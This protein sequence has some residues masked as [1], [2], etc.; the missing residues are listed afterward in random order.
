MGLALLAEACAAVGDSAHAETLAAMLAPFAGRHLVSPVAAYVGPVNRYL[1]LLASARG[2]HE[3]S[4][5]L[6]ATARE[7]AGLLGAR[8]MLAT[9]ALDEARVHA[10]RSAHTAGA[11]RAHEAAALASE[12]G[13]EA[14]SARAVQLA[15]ELSA[16]GPQTTSAERMPTAADAA[17]WGGALR[18]EGDVWNLRWDGRTMLLRDSKGLRYLARLL[19]DPGVEVHSLDL[20]RAPASAPSSAHARTQAILGDELQARPSGEPGMAALDD[21]A[22]REYRRRLTELREELA[23]AEDWGDPERAVAAREEM[24]AIAHELA[25]AVGLSG[26]D[27]QTGSSAERA[28]VNATR[29]I[30]G[31]ISRIGDAD[32]VLGHHLATTVKTGTFCSYRPRPGSPGWDIGW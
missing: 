13:L 23:E 29:A 4:L 32:D 25:A 3:R 5:E 14:L 20:V 10:A 22:K 9:I 6:L 27:R 19:A 15:D 21:R 26:R 31:A 11:R 17:R 18:R 2:D 16:A 7:E 8:P 28:R 12:L 1:G 30:R 24:E